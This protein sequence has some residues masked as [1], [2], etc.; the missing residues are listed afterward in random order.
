MHHHKT[1]YSNNT[2]IIIIL[3][4]LI[5]V[6]ALVFCCA[7][8]CYN[9]TNNNNCCCDNYNRN[10]SSCYA[11]NNCN[12]AGAVSNNNN[13]NT[14]SAPV[15]PKKCPCACPD[16][17]SCPQPCPCPGA[18]VAAPQCVASSTNANK[19]SCAALPCQQPFPQPPTCNSLPS[20]PC[21][22]NP[23]ANNNNNNNNNYNVNTC[24]SGPSSYINLTALSRPV[25]LVQQTTTDLLN[26]LL[27]LFATDPRVNVGSLVLLR[28][29]PTENPQVRYTVGPPDPSTATSG[30]PFAQQLTLA[31]QYM[32]QLGIVFT[33]GVVVQAY[34]YTH[35][36]LN[37]LQQLLPV[38]VSASVQ[39]LGAWIGEGPTTDSSTSILFQVP[40]NQANSCATAIR[41]YQ[42]KTGLT[43]C[44]VA[45]PTTT[46][47]TTT[48][49]ATTC[50]PL[51][52]ATRT[53]YTAYGNSIGQINALIAQIPALQSFV[54]L[55]ENTNRWSIRFVPGCADPAV[56][57]TITQLA[58][59]CNCTIS[60]L[61]VQ[62]YGYTN[63]VPG[64]LLRMYGAVQAIVNL[65]G[66]W[67]GEAPAQFASTSFDFQVPASQ[68]NTLLNLFG[69]IQFCP[70]TS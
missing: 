17:C 61:V 9:C 12:V 11:S 55:Q 50:Q 32:T 47:P 25:F 34:G 15:T 33:E 29:C 22:F 18:N 54:V 57:N 19:S 46:P 36:D 41:Q 16:P 62:A 27:N 21:P 65:L 70:T 67:M 1:M 23:C 38:V 53:V 4:V 42:F 20:S 8:S 26:Q 30:T 3:L 44:C 52:T 24:N 51:L 69:Q 39:V 68:L 59:E 64:T 14:T 43:A 56:P 37:A 5:V 6:L 63:A 45:A 49:T 10:N 2:L 40:A 66:V 48:T 7:A 13:N 60:S 28:N 31:R 35:A 58:Q